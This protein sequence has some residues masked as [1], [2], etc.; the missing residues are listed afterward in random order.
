MEVDVNETDSAKG[1]CGSKSRCAK[2]LANTV[3]EE[4][5]YGCSD[6]TAGDAE[7]RLVPVKMQ[8]GWRRIAHI[9]RPGRSTG[10]QEDGVT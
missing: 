7:L 9:R 4:Y 2:L 6:V 3:I 1:R 8:I 5:R 10:P